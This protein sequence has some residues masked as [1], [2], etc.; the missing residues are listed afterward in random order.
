MLKLV[1]YT[2]NQLLIKM[3]KIDYLMRLKGLTKRDICNRAKIS[4]TTFD[5]I[6]SGS[7]CKLSNLQKIADTLG[8]HVTELFECDATGAIDMSRVHSSGDQSVY[9]DVVKIGDEQT[10]RAQEETICSLRREVEHLE[11]LISEKDARIE[12]LKER[13]NELK[14]K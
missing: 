13:I 11:R 12:E 9:G 6:L 14:G 5:S 7:D 2:D 1:K 10:A 4:R 8:V 3:Y